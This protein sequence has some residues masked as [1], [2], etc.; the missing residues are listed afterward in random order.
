MLWTNLLVISGLILVAAGSALLIVSFYQ[1]REIRKLQKEEE[2]A[3][4][5]EQSIHYQDRGI[6]R[7]QML[8]LAMPDALFTTDASGF[9]D[10]WN[11]H[12][13]TLTG[14]KANDAIGKEWHAFLKVASGKKEDGELR[15]AGGAPPPWTN[16]ECRLATRSGKELIVLVSSREIPNSVGEA[17][18]SVAVIKDI[19]PIKELEERLR[20][21][22]EDLRLANARLEELARQQSRFLSHVSHELRTPLNSILGF[23]GILLDELT[24]PLNEE[25]SRQLKVIYRQSQR[26]LEQINQLL[27]AARIESGRLTFDPRNFS[28]PPVILDAID[29]LEPLA[30]EKNL[31]LRFERPVEPVP[32]VYADPWRVEQVLINLLSNAIKY[33]ETGKVWVECGVCRDEPVPRLEIRV[34]DT[35]IGIE[36]DEQQRMFD[37]F[38][39]SNSARSKTRSGL[40]LGLAITKRLVE[41]QQGSI[42]VQSKP[43]EGTTMAIRLPVRAE[44]DSSDPN[45]SCIRNEPVRV[46]AEDPIVA[47]ALMRLLTTHGIGSV[48]SASCSDMERSIANRSADHSPPRVLLVDEPM[49][50]DVHDL[51]SRRIDDGGS[52]PVCLILTL[53]RED[54]SSGPSGEIY[55]RKPV[56]PRS[57]IDLLQQLLASSA[58]D[59]EVPGVLAEVK[60]DEPHG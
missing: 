54:R 15:G 55:L 40:G 59:P 27:E 42:S 32:D 52:T 24:G 34:C 60:K 7:L 44:V 19:T 28:V 16:R 8:L 4:L 11:E 58:S 25:Q 3:R 49:W 46:V 12:A 23:T 35:G 22:R 56:T 43:G 6:E 21:Q 2:K 51:L 5:L 38:W 39:Q 18:G 50:P 13:E 30:R 9:I 45:A 53:D 41:M 33:T 1:R 48:W 29:S 10:Y 17:S 37:E 26:L 57:L 36:A 20:R 47:H 14:Y 31:E